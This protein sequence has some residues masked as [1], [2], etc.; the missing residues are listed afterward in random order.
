MSSEFKK[1][2]LYKRRNHELDGLELLMFL[3]SNDYTHELYFLTNYHDV[4]SIYDPKELCFATEEEAR[5]FSRLANFNASV[6]V[7]MLIEALSEVNS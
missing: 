4:V 6:R 5:E 2:C 7:N 1:G 3:A